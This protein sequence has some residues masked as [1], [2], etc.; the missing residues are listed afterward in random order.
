MIERL[1]QAIPFEEFGYQELLD[2]LREFH[3]PRNK[4]NSL[5]RQGAIIRVKKGLYIF[6]DAWRRRPFSRELLANLIYGPSY[7]SL[8]YALSHHGLIPEGVPTVT[9]VTTG[10]S[11]S[12]DTPVGRFTYRRISLAAFRTG[13]DRVEAGDGRAYLM[14]IPEKALADLVAVSRGSGPRSFKETRSR[15]LDNLRLDPAALAALEPERLE[16]IA[17]HWRVRKV[18]LLPGVVRALRRERETAHA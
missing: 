7:I 14:A 15:L 13:M 18:R 8:E 12:F 11:R 16:E 5:L 3:Y 2:T 9:S 17:G 4:I 1:R 10:R 6:G